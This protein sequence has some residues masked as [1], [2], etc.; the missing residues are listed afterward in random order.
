M[1]IHYFQRYHQKENVATANTM[2]LLSRFYLFSSEKF[3][4]FLESTL[5]SGQINPGLSITL[6]EKGEGSVP[7]AIISQDSFKIVVET[8]TSDWFYSNQLI[9]H[10]NS[11]SDEKYKLILTLA[12]ESIKKNKLEEFKNKIDEVNLTL[13]HKILY[14]N[15]TF[16]ELAN[17]IQETLDDR[18]VEMQDILDDYI[19]F[20]SSSGLISDSWKYM[21]VQLTGQSLDFNVKEGIYFDS[22]ERGF[23]PHEYLGLYQNKSVRAIGK[24][25]ARISAEVKSNDEIEFTAE[26]GDV[27]EERK[28]KIKRAIDFGEMKGWDL[29]SIKHRYFFV[30]KFY[31]T[32]FKKN[33]L[34]APMGSRI[35]D[36]TDVLNQKDIKLPET[37]EIAKLLRNKEWS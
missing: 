32:D 25:V 1:K 29:K 4:R 14:I 2:L 15:A 16:E 22:N 7:D 9:R 18:D 33:T 37:E 10:L 34:R 26:V 17:A 12:P 31:E 24:I 5:F 27:T 30:E 11:F 8:K 13:T 21:R 23:R 6:Q 36:L 3:Y 19:D 28:E 35:F 20:C